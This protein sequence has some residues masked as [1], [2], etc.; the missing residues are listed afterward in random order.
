[1]LTY[2]PIDRQFECYPRAGGR[3]GG[4]PVVTSSLS[5]SCELGLRTIVTAPQSLAASLA[6]GQRATSRGHGFQQLSTE[7]LLRA[8]SLGF[9]LGTSS[10]SE[11]FLHR[12]TGPTTRAHTVDDWITST[13]PGQ[14]GIGNKVLQLRSDP[15][16]AL[17]SSLSARSSSKG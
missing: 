7:A 11:P 10:T 13:G 16:K 17:T 15:I 6:N 9:R 5:H 1:M 12:S 8:I 2:S 14:F 3:P 4:E